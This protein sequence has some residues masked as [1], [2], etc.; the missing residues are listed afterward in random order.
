MD[1][2]VKPGGDEGEDLPP[3]SGW[4]VETGRTAE[5]IPSSL[6]S[7]ADGAGPGNPYGISILEAAKRHL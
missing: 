1:D 4:S 5:N 2:R 3:Q 7:R 6:P